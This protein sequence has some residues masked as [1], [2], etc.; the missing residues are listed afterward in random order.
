MKISLFVIFCLLLL[1]CQPDTGGENQHDTTTP[2]NP[3][4]V[5][6]MSADSTPKV[7]VNNQEES[8]V[9]RVGLSFHRWYLAHINNYESE[10]PTDAFVIE[11]EE[12]KCKLE[13]EPYFAELRKLGMVSE[14]FIESEKERLQACADEMAQTDWSA[15]QEGQVCEMLQYFYWIKSQETMEF[16]EASTSEVKAESAEVE[17]RF[18][19]VFKDKK[20]YWPNLKVQANL[21]LE[22]S[23]WRIVGMEFL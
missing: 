21:A 19:D 6:T 18:Y 12:G 20:N 10:V 4:K 16:V 14:T 17:I 2:E 7:N 11:G 3:D 9:E 15:Y 5:E 23:V 22:D 1:S 8:A 13:T